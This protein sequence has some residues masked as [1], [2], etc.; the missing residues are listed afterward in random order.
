MS[1]GFEA[2]QEARVQIRKEMALGFKNE[3]DARQLVRNDLEMVKERIRKLEQ[4]SGSTVC[5]EA[6]TAAVSGGS[7]TFARPPSAIAAQYQSYFIP[8]R[9]EFKCWITDHRKCSLQGITMEEIKDFVA[10]LE[11]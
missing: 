7:G 8:R 9:M 4:G 3:E 5:S 2:E 10:D 11:K 6:H 1:K